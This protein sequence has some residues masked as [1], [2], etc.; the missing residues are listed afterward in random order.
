MWTYHTPYSSHMAKWKRVNTDKRLVWAG[1]HTTQTE[2]SPLK[3]GF[4][5][6][7]RPSLNKLLNTDVWLNEFPI[8][9]SYLW[10]Q[11]RFP[12]FPRCPFIKKSYSH[13]S[14][15]KCFMMHGML[16]QGCFDQHYSNCPVRKSIIELLVI[17]NHW[18]MDCPQQTQ[19][20]VSRHLHHHNWWADSWGTAGKLIL[21]DNLYL[22]IHK[23][24]ERTNANVLPTN[25]ESY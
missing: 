14:C 17:G 15:R 2:Q 20:H 18:W 8:N 1:T 19:L 16:R 7:C 10:S 6:R 4:K 3:D 11:V 22:Q 9:S 13:F 24:P 21:E 25:E 12:D 5:K 23:M